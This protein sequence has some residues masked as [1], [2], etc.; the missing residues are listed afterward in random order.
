M[1]Y[2]QDRFPELQSEPNWCATWVIR[3]ILSCTSLLFLAA[4][5]A[6]P[7]LLYTEKEIDGIGA[8]L[9]MGIY[10][11][12][13]LWACIALFRHIQKNRKKFVKKITVNNKGI[14]F[15]KINGKTES[16]LYSQLKKSGDRYTADVYG[17]KIRLYGERIFFVHLKHGKEAI[18]FN[19]TDAFSGNTRDLRA[20]FLQG[21]HLFRPDLRISPEV[22]SEFF[23]NSKTF[24]FEQR[25]F[26]RTL[27]AAIII[28]IL[29]FLASYLWAQ[30]RFK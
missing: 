17:K 9:F 7:L 13:L 14:H 11:P 19:H 10:Y 6:T 12:L 29:F 28:G 26:R 30:Y 20:H 16:V 25:F 5:F 15:H 2:H 1:I 27:V 23:I 8:T 4:F 21:I 3:I 24:K 22:Y 18:Y